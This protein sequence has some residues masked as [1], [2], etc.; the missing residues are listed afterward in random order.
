MKV[1]ISPLVERAIEVAKAGKHTYKIITNNPEIYEGATLPAFKPCPCGNYLSKNR[2]CSCELKEIEEYQK[3]LPYTDI[4]VKAPDI[5]FEDITFEEKIDGEAKEL[6][7][8]A[9]KELNLNC[10]E[11]SSTIRVGKTIA[12]L[13]DSKELKGQHIAEALQYQIEGKDLK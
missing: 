13:D 3:A 10:K 9:M 7:K 2:E 12:E 5:R 6:L 1:K 8:T 11:L 4:T